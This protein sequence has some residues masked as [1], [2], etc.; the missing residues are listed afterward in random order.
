MLPTYNI[1]ICGRD[2]KQIDI[3]KLDRYIVNRAFNDV[4]D[5]NTSEGTITLNPIFITIP[6]DILNLKYI[7]GAVIVG[8]PNEYEDFCRKI[9]GN[10]VLYYDNIEIMFNRLLAKINPTI[11]LIPVHKSSPPR[12]IPYLRR[13]D[14]HDNENIR[15]YN[16]R[17]MMLLKD[18]HHY[19]D[20][21]AA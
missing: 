16:R 21:T 5:L 3:G 6:E 20:N 14:L 2:A 18:H 8:L 15:R 1:V 17:N 10:I 9:T 13:Y 4:T 12:P 11:R 19:V 7:D